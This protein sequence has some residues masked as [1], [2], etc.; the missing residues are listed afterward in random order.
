MPRNE[1]ASQDAHNQHEEA[2]DQPAP[3][4]LVG[5]FSAHFNAHAAKPVT[6]RTSLPAGAQRVRLAWVLPLLKAVPT[7]LAIGFAT[8]FWWDFQGVF[9]VVWDYSLHMEGFLR[10]L[11][12][13][14]LIGYLT[15]WLAI[16][17]L[18]HPRERR[19]VWG[20]GLIP[21]QRDRVIDKLARAISDDLVTADALATALEASGIV[22]R[23]SVAIGSA[24]RSALAD[25]SFRY[26]LRTAVRD[27]MATYLADEAQRRTLTSSIVDHLDQLATESLSNRLVRWLQAHRR[28]ELEKRINRLIDRLPEMLAL[29]DGVLD[30]W[31]DQIPALWDH[32]A[33]ATQSWATHAIKAAVSTLDVHGM[34]TS[35]MQ[36]FE[37]KRFETLIK[38]ASNDQLDYI[39]YIGAVLGMMGGLV[40]FDPVSALL[41]LGGLT[42]ALGAADVLLHRVR[43][44]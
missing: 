18:F 20:Q 4:S 36:S 44:A 30:N 1:E 42:I 2:N 38:S 13:S 25:P 15:N 5:Q 22:S 39:R 43:S 26:E 8:S 33:D 23:F 14:G 11:S 41:A 6:P 29:P 31:I 7:V 21:A 24:S 10:T 16:T 32:H 17:M 27:G 3:S 40:I 28:A 34:I 37:D 12:V 35:N 9:A 19:P